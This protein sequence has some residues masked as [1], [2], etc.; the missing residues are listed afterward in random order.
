MAPP[1][2]RTR[3]CSPDKVWLRNGCF[4]MSQENC[5][6]VTII[7]PARNE[8]ACLGSCLESLVT[9]AG[10]DFEIIVVD[11]G[12]TDRTREIAK[13]FS[14]PRTLNCVPARN[15]AGPMTGQPGAGSLTRPTPDEGAPGYGLRHERDL[16]ARRP[17]TV[18]SAPP[19]RDM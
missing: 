1:G 5:S 11:D 6:V 15:D 7:V 12:S 10:I 4:P 8:E 16:R 3:K 2:R 14:E 17:V 13:S 9:Q 18:I 19:L